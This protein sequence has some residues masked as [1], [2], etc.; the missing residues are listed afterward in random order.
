MNN[1]QMTARVGIFFALGVV[2]IFVVFEALSKGK[3]SREDGYVLT[4]QFRN[5]KELKAGDEVR[6]AGV[7]VG[8]VSSTRLVGRRAEAVL[9]IDNKVKVAKDSKA[10]IAMAGLLGSNYVSLD[11]GSDDIGFLDPNAQLV[12]VDTADLNS[13]VSQLG[14]IGKKVDTALSGLSGALN[15][16]GQAGNPGLIG[17]IDRMVDDNREKINTITTNLEEITAKINRGEGTIGKLVNDAKLHDELLSTVGEI[18]LAAT[19]AK[20][21]VKEAQTIVDQVKSGQGTL[22]VLLYDQQAGENIK[23]TF[24]NVREITDKIN[25]GEGT[26]GKLINDD[27]LFIQAQGAIKKLDKALDSMGDE[28]PISAVGTVAGKLF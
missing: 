19:Q 22:G 26:V 17:K 23:V 20:D 18:K 2:L 1:N 4:A 11:L 21:F 13:I 25:K 12:S 3:L 16:N 10:T 9:L 8:S 14:D 7:K 24:R 5:L 6:M 28:A 15:G 27:Q